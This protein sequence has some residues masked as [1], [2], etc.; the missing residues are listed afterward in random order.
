VETSSALHRYAQLTV[1]A[2]FFVI[3]A[4]AMV[5]STGSGMA[6]PDWPTSFGSWMPKMQGGVFYEHGH[7]MVAAAAGILVTVLALWAQFSG[8]RPLVRRLAWYALLAIL[9]QGLLGGTTVLLG[10]QNGWDH[11]APLVSMMH[12]SLAQ[13]LFAILVM[14]AVVTAPGWLAQAQVPDPTAIGGQA[15]GLR[16]MALGLVAAVYLQIILGAVMRHENAGLM[17]PDFPLSYGRLV[18]DI[19]DWRVGLN[20]AHR[21]GALM[22]LLLGLSLAARVLKEA[23]SAWIKAPAKVLI[24]ALV[25]QVCLGACV[26]WSRLQ[27]LVTSAHVIGGAL[28]LASSVVLALRIFHVPR[29]DV[30]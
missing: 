25:L 10:T 19:Q 11:T 21:L 2:A 5:T 6:V 23:S 9:A 20:Y 14:E 29:Q 17:I 22:V 28:V 30:V 13:G 8:Q 27:P 1:A 7:R 4:G 3:F 15:S 16:S 12:A 18:P 24:G 26:V